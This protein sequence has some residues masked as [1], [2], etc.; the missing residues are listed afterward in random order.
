MTKYRQ[1]KTDLTPK[2]TATGSDP[3]MIVAYMVMVFF[4]F[5]LGFATGW[6]FWG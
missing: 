5:A 2:I 4:G 3:G 6:L 1:H